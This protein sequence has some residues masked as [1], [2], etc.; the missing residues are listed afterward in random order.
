MP[1]LKFEVTQLGAGILRSSLSPEEGLLVYVD[2][3]HA[4]KGLIL[5]NELHMLYLLTPVSLSFRVNWRLYHQIFKRL[6]P[7]EQR[8]CEKIGI[9]EELIVNYSHN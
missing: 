7:I 6:M 4:Q 1:E 9:T 8:I 5:S 3:Q 2:L